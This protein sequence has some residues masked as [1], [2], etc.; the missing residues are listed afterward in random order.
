MRPDCG[1]ISVPGLM[2]SFGQTSMQRAQPLQNS[3]RTKGLGRSNV[4][5]GMI[6]VGQAAERVGRPARLCF[7]KRKTSRA[8]EASA[9]EPKS[10]PSFA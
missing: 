3:G 9:F 1:L 4:G 5:V 8:P 2:Q 6:S 7:S 10:G